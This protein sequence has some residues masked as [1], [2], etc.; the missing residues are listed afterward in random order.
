MNPVPPNSLRDTTGTGRPA[1][2]KG[3]DGWNRRAGTVR[4]PSRARPLPTVQRSTLRISP[5][6][7]QPVAEQ[8]VVARG[9][10]RW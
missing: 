5:L 3:T 6:V 4:R 7:G 9:D 8:P 1:A 2:A 10:G